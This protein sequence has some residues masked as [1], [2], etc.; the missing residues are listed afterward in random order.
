MRFLNLNP[1]TN[2]TFKSQL[3]FFK[4]ALLWLWNLL[5]P[6][7]GMTINNKLY[8]ASDLKQIAC[9]PKFR[10]RQPAAEHINSPRWMLSPPPSGFINEQ[11]KQFVRYAKLFWCKKNLI[12][13]FLTPT[14]IFRTIL[15]LESLGVMTYIVYV[16]AILF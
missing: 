10:T 8:A 2:T 16:F 5:L 12:T 13:F 1:S 3:W 15:I 7:I 14:P 6:Y 4:Y 9:V 11:L